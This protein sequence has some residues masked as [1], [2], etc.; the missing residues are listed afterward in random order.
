MPM[1]LSDEITKFVLLESYFESPNF[2]AKVHCCVVYNNV[3][4]KSGQIMNPIIAKV[5]TISISFYTN[6]TH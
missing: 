3:F 5:D 4:C 1:M 6:G 2:N